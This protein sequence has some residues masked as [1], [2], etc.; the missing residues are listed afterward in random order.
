MKH[1]RGAATTAAACDQGDFVGT[2]R[3]QGQRITPAPVART[4]RP[5]GF[6]TTATAE[7]GS[8]VAVASTVPVVDPR[9]AFGSPRRRQRSLHRAY[10]ACRHR[11]NPSARHSDRAAACTSRQHI[12]LMRVGGRGRS[13][14]RAVKPT[15]GA[16]HSAPDCTVA[17][18]LTE[19]LSRTSVRF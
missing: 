8:C 5:T 6:I 16:H 13:S 11:R 14:G 15:A 12:H 9:S 2:R 1:K 7:S 3:R 17:Q 18:E 4:P 10:H 19:F